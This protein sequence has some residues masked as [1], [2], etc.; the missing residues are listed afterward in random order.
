M[1]QSLSPAQ[2]FKRS[3][4]CL[5]SQTD[6]Q[7]ERVNQILEQYL[8]LYVSYHKDDWNTWLP[9]AEFSHN[10]SDHSSTKQSPFFIVNGRD[11]QFYS[12]QITQDNPAGKL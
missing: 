5:P 9:L 8:W 3:S 6:G 1:D 11:P 12:V 10:N 2:D 7:T 4:N